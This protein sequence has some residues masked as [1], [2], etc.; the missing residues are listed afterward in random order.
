L[1]QALG[2]KDDVTGSIPIEDV[3]HFMLDC[4]VLDPV[5]ERFPLFYQPTSLSGRCRDSH[6]N[7]VFNHSD[8]VQVVRC[9]SALKN[10]RE[11]CLH[12]LDDGR[13]SEIMPEGYIAIVSE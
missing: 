12:L 1:C 5:R 7:F 6:L 10:R 13:I 8:H 2:Y 9:I 4:R 3:V 11:S